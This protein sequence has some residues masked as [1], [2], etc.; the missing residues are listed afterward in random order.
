MIL[1]LSTNRGHHK[2][3]ARAEI[4]TIGAVEGPTEGPGLHRVL[5]PTQTAALPTPIATN[6]NGTNDSPIFFRP[7]PGPGA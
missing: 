2:K 5:A 4:K 1:L 7:G 6:P 3:N